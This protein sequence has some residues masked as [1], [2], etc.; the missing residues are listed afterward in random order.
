MPAIGNGLY[1]PNFE[2]SWPLTIDETSSPAIIGVSSSPERVALEPFTTC[3]NSGRYVTAPKSA[4][5]TMKPMAAETAKIRLRKSVSG[6]I[7]SAA[8]DSIH[9]NAGTSTSASTISATI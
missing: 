6:R 1:R 2:I 4:I 7:G 5:P 3:R 9:R 8:R